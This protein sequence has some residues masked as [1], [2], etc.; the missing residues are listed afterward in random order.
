MTNQQ[1]PKYKCR[2]QRPGQKN[3]K[4]HPTFSIV[5]NAQTIRKKRR[6]TAFPM[7]QLFMPQNYPFP[8][9]PEDPVTLTIT[10]LNRGVSTDG[11]L[12]DS[13]YVETVIYLTLQRNDAI[14]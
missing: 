8:R 10:T 2:M 9:V 7:Q 6:P 11:S 14:R 13:K 4:H 5:G 12:Y 3:K 1:I